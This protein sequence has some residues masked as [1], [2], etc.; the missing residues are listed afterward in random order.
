MQVHFRKVIPEHLHS[1]SFDEHS[2]PETRGNELEVEHSM[3]LDRLHH[4]PS[5]VVNDTGNSKGRRHLL[6]VEFLY[7]SLCKSAKD[8]RKNKQ[9]PKYTKTILKHLPMA[10]LIALMKVFFQ[11]SG[12]KETTSVNRAHGVRM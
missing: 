4:V 8:F 3:S 9:S 5:N 12:A 10:I 2:V 1:T 7:N 11:L 6:C